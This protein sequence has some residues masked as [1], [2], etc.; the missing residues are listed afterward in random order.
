MS[1]MHKHNHEEC[2]CGHEHHH[3]HGHDHCCDDGCG[4]GHEHGGEVNKKEFWTKI[5]IS[6]VFF[7]A[8]Y[9]INEAFTQPA[10]LKYAAMACFAVSYLVVGFEIIREAVEGIMHKNFF[11]E[12]FLMAIASVG[13]FAIG[14]YAEGCSVVLLY[15]IGEFL[16][17]L[18][19]GKSRKS[20]TDM[21]KSA[22]QKVHIEKGGKLVDVDPEDVQPGDI[23]TVNPGEKIELDGVVESGSAEVDTSALT[24]ESIPASVSAGDTVYSG[25]VNADGMLKIKA[26]KAYSDS[27]VSRI[28]DMIQDADSK[29]SHAEKFITRFAKYYTPAVCLVALLII[30]VPPIFFGGEWKEWAYRGLSALVVSCPCAIVIS[31]PLSFFSGLGA[32]SKQGILI[33]GSNYLELLSKFDVAVFDKTGTITSGKFEYVN[34]ECVHC[35][36]TDKKNHRELLGLIAA[37]EKYSTHPIA[38]SV[39]LAFGQYA[40]HLQV[41]DAKNYA[42]MGVSAVVNGV[43]YYAGNEKLMKQVG[44][45][46]KETNLIGTAIYLCSEK[47]FLGNIVFADVI[48]TDSK[49]AIA[50]LGKMGV[51]KTVMLTGDKE[52]IAADMAKKA[53][54]DEYYAKLLPQ[55]KVEKVKALQ[56]SGNDIVLYTGDGIND[57]P[58]LAQSDVG[59]AMGGIGSDVA[60]EAADVVIMSDSLSKL[61]VG[62]KIAKKTMNIVHENIIFSI[63]VKV[64]IIIGCAIGIFNENAMWLAVFGDVGVCLIAVANSLRAM[65]VSKKDRKNNTH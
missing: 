15:T 41:S 2:S 18:A 1:E 63:A 7:I 23:F 59:V 32:S 57:A 46:F 43:K 54:I 28:L 61:P 6:G 30:L 55:E 16:Q 65:Y 14:E 9:I 26:T 37:C 10:S 35:H 20:I 44:V 8:G 58:V 3:E 38:K 13:A 11:N 25:S 29:K 51:K 50:R 5:I 33:K 39:C 27:T 45:D 40:D 22:P 62:R 56:N 48:K 34:C 53:G 31:I 42:G 47:E 64:L 12:N 19:V 60:I 49:E 4:C 36:C 24:G 21:I 17:D 52:P